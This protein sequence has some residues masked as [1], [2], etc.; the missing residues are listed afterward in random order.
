MV[1]SSHALHAAEH[2]SEWWGIISVE[3]EDDMHDFYIIREASDANDY[4]AS[5]VK[6]FL[7][8]WWNKVKEWFLKI[9][10]YMK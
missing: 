1:G 5:D 3:L 7:E 10:R 4:E 2:I 9:N 8:N 6:K